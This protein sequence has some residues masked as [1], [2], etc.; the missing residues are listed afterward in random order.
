MSECSAWI[1]LVMGKKVEARATPRFLAWGQGWMV[2]LFT[3]TEHRSSRSEERDNGLSFGQAE[4]L[5][6]VEMSNY[7]ALNPER[8][9]CARDKR[10]WSQL[11]VGRFS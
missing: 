11:P 2:A 10:G 3:Y 9:V 1:G 5:M 8:E 6:S 7:M 4:F